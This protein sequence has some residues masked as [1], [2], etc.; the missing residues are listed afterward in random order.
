MT[1][2]SIRR[3]AKVLRREAKSLKESNAIGSRQ[4]VYRG[5][6]EQRYVERDKRDHDEMIDLARQLEAMAKERN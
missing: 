3:A 5:P 1:P 6:D 2:Q 4:W